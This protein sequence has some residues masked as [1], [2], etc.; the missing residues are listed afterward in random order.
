M[1]DFRLGRLKGRHVVIWT[2]DDGKRRRYRLEAHTAREAEREARDLILRLDAPPAGMTVAQ[3]WDAYRIEMGDRRQGAKVAQAG[4]VVLPHFGHLS[5]GQITVA[6]CR[7]YTARRRSAG[8]KDGTIRSELGCLRSAILWAQKTRLIYSAP[9]IEMPPTPAPRDRYLSREE[10]DEL[11][12]AAIDPHIR[13]AMLLMLTTAGRSGAVLELTWGRVDLAN[14]TIKLATNDLG[15]RKG[16]ATEPINDTLMAA[17]Q[18]ARQAA[19]SEYVVEWG[20]RRVGS[21][22]TGFN[23]AVARAGIAHC[24]PHD[25]RR[26]AGRFMAEAGVPIEE[27]AEYLGHTNPNITR[28]TYA[29]FSPGHLRRAAGSLEFGTPKLVQRTRGQ[30]PKPNLSI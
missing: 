29:R 2:D 6:D 26:T 20:G 10:V 9:P 23:A 22:K 3:V 7:G 21:I 5:V 27:I 16:R 30:S 1:R 18:D 15:P 25:L 14:R 17:L 28:S 12:A 13:L 8:R 19:V 24:T 11:L 4:G